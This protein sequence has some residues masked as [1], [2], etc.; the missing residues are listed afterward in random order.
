MGFLWIA[1]KIGI[2]GASSGKSPGPGGAGGLLK[3]TSGY[4]LTETGFFLL[5]E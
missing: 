2:C 1:I 3:E 5:M 4:L